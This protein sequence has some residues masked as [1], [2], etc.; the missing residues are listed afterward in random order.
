MMKLKGRNSK[1]QFIKNH[2]VPKDWKDKWKEKDKWP[3][4]EQNSAWKGD[5]VS[6]G[7]LHMWVSNQLGNPSKCSKCGKREDETKKHRIIQW[8][9]I[10]QKYK[11]DVNDWIALCIKCHREKDKPK[12]GH[13]KRLIHYNNK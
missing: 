1:G 3:R 12:K 8:A 4:G 7:G 2:D 10:S 11:R 6:Y 13:N 5:D 9:N